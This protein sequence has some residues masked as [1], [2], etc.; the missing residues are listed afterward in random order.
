MRRH[1]DSGSILKT[2]AN[3]TIS[4]AVARRRCRSTLAISFRVHPS[5]VAVVVCDMRKSLR[6]AARTRAIERSRRLMMYWCFAVTFFFDCIDR[7]PDEPRKLKHSLRARSHSAAISAHMCSL[8]H[9][10]VLSIVEV[11]IPR[12]VHGELRQAIPRML[13]CR[14]RTRSACPRAPSPRSAAP[15]AMLIPRP[16]ASARRASLGRRLK[17]RLKRQRGS[18]QQR[19]SRDFASGLARVGR[20]HSEFESV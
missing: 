2:R 1:S 10:C 16:R 15:S 11:F 18:L 14:N 7:A 8:R 17:V 12:S 9:I 5:A 4:A 13:R 6:V 20:S 19:Q 3:S